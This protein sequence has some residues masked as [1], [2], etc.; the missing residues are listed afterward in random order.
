MRS[1]DRRRTGVTLVIGSVLLL[2]LHVVLVRDIHGP[3][4]VPDE[5]GYLGNARWL[6]GTSP[7]WIMAE[8]PYYGFGYALFIAPL[9]RV[10]H[11]PETLYRAVLVVNALLATSLF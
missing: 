7:T 10:I 4:V 1:P 8:T 5:A 6:S 2:A 11:D 3:S 9:F